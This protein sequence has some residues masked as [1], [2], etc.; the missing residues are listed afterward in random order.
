L[1]LGRKVRGANG[2]VVGRLQEFLAERE[3][4]SWV[5][6]G[7]DLGPD[8]LLERLA[9]RHIGWLPGDKPHGYRARWD[10]IDISDP[11]RLRL[12]VPLEELSPLRRR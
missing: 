9:V 12:T 7:C 11:E 4:E 5:V 2:R 6:T 3:G 10:Q 1:L 8:A